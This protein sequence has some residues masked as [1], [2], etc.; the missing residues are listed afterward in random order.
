MTVPRTMYR[1][2]SRAPAPTRADRL[3]ALAAEVARLGND[4]RGGA[5][6]FVVTKLSTLLKWGEAAGGTVG[7]RGE[8]VQLT[9]PPGLLEGMAQTELRRFARQMVVDVRSGTHF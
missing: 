3:L 2:A 4:A 9:L 1:Q 6:N 8:V 7:T 5:E